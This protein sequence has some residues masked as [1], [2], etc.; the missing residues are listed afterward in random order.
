MIARRGFAASC[1]ARSG[2]FAAP[3][4]AARGSPW[5]PLRTHRDAPSRSAWSGPGL[6]GLAWPRLTVAADR[7]A[8]RVAGGLGPDPAQGRRL[9][10]RAVPHRYRGVPPLRGDRPPLSLQRVR[11][12]GRGG[13]QGP[14]EEAAAR[15]LPP[16]HHRPAARRRRGRPRLHAVGARQA[17]RHAA[18]RAPIVPDELPDGAGYDAIIEALQGQRDRRR[19]VPVRR[20]RAGAGRARARPQGGAG[21]GRQEGHRQ[22]QRAAAQG[23]GSRPASS[24]T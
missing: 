6:L 21:A 15:G 17:R 13:G 12:A 2:Q 1:I 8:C 9:A 24:R 22:H 5:T 11:R 16:R 3:G 19:Q 18:M 20:R 23:A 10:V 14:A 7:L 4:A